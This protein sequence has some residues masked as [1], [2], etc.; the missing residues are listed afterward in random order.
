MAYRLK[1]GRKPSR[2]LASAVNRQLIGAIQQI[3]TAGPANPDAIHQAR[4]H[5][6]KIRAALRLIQSAPDGQFKTKSTALRETAHLLSTCRDEE[7][8]LTTFDRLTASVDPDTQIGLAAVRARLVERHTAALKVGTTDRIRW[9]L[10]LLRLRSTLFPWPAADAAV[11]AD[12][13]ADGFKRARKSWWEAV[14]SRQEEAVHEWRKRVKIHWYHSRLLRDFTPDAFRLRRRLLYNLS[15]IL[16]DFN[17]LSLLRGHLATQPDIFG[18]PEA[19]AFLAE[20]AGTEQTKLLDT[21]L[22]LGRDLF[23]RKTEPLKPRKQAD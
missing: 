18:G 12:G 16:G 8:L 21:A 23:D 3:L 10:A 6:K 13:W 20:L 1:N 11:I 14:L 17:D 22:V 7:V 19:T 9:L 15:M 5:L 2:S 4:L